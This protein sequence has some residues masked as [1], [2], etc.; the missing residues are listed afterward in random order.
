MY[1]TIFKNST[2]LQKKCIAEW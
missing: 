1:Y 2:L